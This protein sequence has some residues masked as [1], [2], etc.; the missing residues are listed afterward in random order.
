MRKKI[1]YGKVA[2]N[3]FF[4]FL[5]DFMTGRMP[6]RHFIFFLKRLL[7]FLSKLKHNKFVRIGKKTRMDL[8]IPSFP[9]EA[10][11]TA[12]R[13]FTTYGGKLPD[14][15]VLISV[16]SA[17]RFNCAHCY[18]K[19]DLGKDMDIETL[20]RVVKKLQEMNV[21]FFNI[22]GGEPFLVYNRLKRV[23]EAIDERSEVWVNSTGDGMTPE[24]LKELKALNLTAV[25]FS[26]HSPDPEPFNAFMGSDRAWDTMVNGVRLCHDADIPVAFNMCVL[27]E[28]FVNGTFERLM[29]KAKELNASIVQIIKPKPAGG[30]L[31][32]GVEEFGE[33]GLRAVKTLAA[34]YN[35]E[36]AFRSFP[37]ISAQVIE[38]DGAMF[39]CTAGGTDRFYIN[40]KGDLQPC[41]FLNISFGNISRDDFETIYEK[42]RSYF[43]NPGEQW[44]CE[45]YAPEVLRIYESEGLKS[46]PLD[47]P[48]S[49]RIYSGLDPGKATELYYTIEHK[50]R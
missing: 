28:G 16:T 21:A 3:V 43:K 45:K 13:K 42:M 50:L 27:K 2:L 33:E 9:S 37:S 36:K 23:C 4:H 39:G 29:E 22:E 24:R 7:Y 14:S 5:P 10:F 20:V 35:H 25:M 40:A 17:C 12:C 6:S 18:Q 8:Y 32:C 15:T 30:W 31:E 11:Y 47:E 41:E 1:F 49:R 46:L 38:E 44:L 48:L 26:M 19:K 34:R